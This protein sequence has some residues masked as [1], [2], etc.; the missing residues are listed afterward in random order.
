LTLQEH[1]KMKLSQRI[2]GYGAVILGGISILV[3][4][5]PWFHVVGE[6]YFVGFVLFGAGVWILVGPEVRDSARKALAVRREARRASRRTTRRPGRE[7]VIIDPLLPVRILKLAREQGGT[8][9][10]AQVAMELTVPLD[11]AEAGLNE[12]VRAGNAIPDYD[13]PRAHAFYRFP[14]FAEPEP[15]RLSS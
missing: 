11:H 7:P 5:L 1:V 9:T 13:I 4:A 3:G 2:L 8:L 15:P 14:E 12:C 6:A 10:V